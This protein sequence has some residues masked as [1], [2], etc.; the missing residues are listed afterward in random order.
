MLLF[1]SI[2]DAAPKRGPTPNRKQP[3]QQSK[4]TRSAN[5]SV[6]G[7]PKNGGKTKRQFP[8]IFFQGDSVYP[9]YYIQH[10]SP[11]I[12]FE[13]SFLQ[14]AFLS[15]VHYADQAAYLKKHNLTDSNGKSS[16]SDAKTAAAFEAA[17]GDKNDNAKGATDLK[18]K[19]V[20]FNGLGN[21]N[22][23]NPFLLAKDNDGN[24]LKADNGLP[25]VKAAKL[26]DVNSSVIALVNP[27]RG[28]HLDAVF[29]PEIAPRYEIHYSPQG[30]SLDTLPPFA[31]AGIA[32]AAIGVPPV[33]P[34][35]IGPPAFGPAVGPIPPFGIAPSFNTLLNPYPY[36]YPFLPG[37]DPK[38]L[39][40]NGK[41]HDGKKLDS[42]EQ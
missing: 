9:N 13:N 12:D 21:I 11:L 27:F 35:A 8:G 6:K 25:G 1:V 24:V 34:A 16:S 38:G 39:K 5:P 23:V 10:S 41:G 15:G 4:F 33:G 26:G 18:A 2:I 17:F 14:A 40:P 28:G 22:I 36:P 32:S 31:G 19:V 30:V 37:F 3:V 7:S 29:G 42:T 20:A